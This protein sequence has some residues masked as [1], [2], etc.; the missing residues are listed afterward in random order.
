MCECM[1]VCV[2][3]EQEFY[4]QRKGNGRKS[5]NLTGC[6][7]LVFLPKHFGLNYIN[8]AACK[9]SFKITVT[10]F[11]ATAR[12]CFKQIPKLWDYDRGA[13]VAQGDT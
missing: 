2:K 9:D 7:Q 4:A 13:S 12:H 8:I 3:S 6:L 5:S 11:R 1:R 10:P